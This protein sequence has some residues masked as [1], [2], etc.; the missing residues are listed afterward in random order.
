MTIFDIVV[1]LGYVVIIVTMAIP[2]IKW[3]LR[4]K[5]E[6]KEEDYEEWKDQDRRNHDLHVEKQKRIQSRL[7]YLAEKIRLAETD[8]ERNR[9]K[10]EI[11]L[12]EK[13]RIQVIY[14]KHI[15]EDMTSVAAATD[16]EELKEFAE[17][18]VIIDNLEAQRKNL[19]DIIKETEVEIKENSEFNL[20]QYYNRMVHPQNDKIFGM[21]KYFV[22]SEKLKIVSWW[23]AGDFENLR[24]WNYILNGIGFGL[25]MGISIYGYI[26]LKSIYNG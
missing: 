23:H 2:A 5:F 7:T 6:R 20:M 10:D 12:F 8:E 11:K 17:K 1:I 18:K 4:I 13:L 16:V 14:L 15:E 24:K 3:G 22:D 19:D 26:L 21:K 25:V 9:I